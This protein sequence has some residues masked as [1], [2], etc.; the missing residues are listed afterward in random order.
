MSVNL[1]CPCKACSGWVCE[2]EQDASSTFWGCG[3]CGNVWFKK[4]S[5]ELDISSAI[6]ESDYRAKV[7]L[8][9]QNGFVGIDIDDEPEDYAELVAEEWD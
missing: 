5:L 8:K 1:R 7:Y 2:V 9:T 4:Q 6:S 3:T